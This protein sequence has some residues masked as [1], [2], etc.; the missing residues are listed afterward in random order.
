MRCRKISEPASQQLQLD[1]S[2]VRSLLLG[3]PSSGAPLVAAK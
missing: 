2:A 3:F 1:T